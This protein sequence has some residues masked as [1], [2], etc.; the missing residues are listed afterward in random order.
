[1]KILKARYSAGE[2][3]L[4]AYE[5]NFALGGLFIPTRRTIPVGEPVVVSVQIGRRTSPLHMRG[6]VVWLRRGRHSEKVRAGMAVEFVAGERKRRD[7]LLSLA[8]GQVA[9][10]PRRHTRL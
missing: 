1:M 2:D 7:F 8:R 9:Q 5:T 4:R 6:I 3:F 10:L